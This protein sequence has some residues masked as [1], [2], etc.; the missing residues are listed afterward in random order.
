MIPQL[1]YDLYILGI[2]FMTLKRCLVC[3]LHGVLVMTFFW[4]RHKADF[5]ADRHRSAF[6]V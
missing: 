6:V 3:D 2:F 4:A 5:R 1:G